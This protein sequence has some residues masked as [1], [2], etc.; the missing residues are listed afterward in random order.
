[1]KKYVEMM[2]AKFREVKYDGRSESSEIERYSDRYREDRDGSATLLGKMLEWANEY[3]EELVREGFGHGVNCRARG[4]QGKTLAPPIEVPDEMD[5]EE[6]EEMQEGE[7]DNDY[8]E[9]YFDDDE[10]GS[11][12]GEYEEA[13]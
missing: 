4:S 6:E 12:G 2:Q 11:D 10:G 7:E 8:V 3:P 13:L 1:M 5:A 9:D